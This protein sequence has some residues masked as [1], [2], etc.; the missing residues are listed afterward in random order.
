[1]EAELRVKCVVQGNRYYT[2]C[3]VKPVTISN[4]L[5]R[6]ETELHLGLIHGQRSIP[7]C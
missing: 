4:A 3:S 7:C 5:A 6:S 1:M 2:A